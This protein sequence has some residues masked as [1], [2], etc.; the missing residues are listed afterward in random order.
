M[1]SWPLRA[2]KLELATSYT[3]PSPK[4]QVS[5]GHLHG[6]T[7]WRRGLGF[8]LRVGRAKKLDPTFNNS[9]LNICMH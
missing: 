4:Y 5:H 7:F 8:V 6:N 3:V 1:Q 2:W 9:P